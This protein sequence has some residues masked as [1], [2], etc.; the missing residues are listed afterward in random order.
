SEYF[1]VVNRV[2]D[3][4]FDSLFTFT[5]LDSNRIPDNEDP[6]SGAEF[7]FF[8][9]DFTNPFIVKSDPNAGGVFRRFVT[10][11]SGVYVWHVDET[12]VA[13]NLAAGLLPNDFASRKGVDLEEA[14]GIQD[15]DRIDSS[16]SFGSH[17]DSFRAGNNDRFGPDSQPNSAASSGAGT[18]I[19]IRDI[20]SPDSVMALTIEIARTYSETR[21]KWMASGRWQPPSVFDV[22]GVGEEELLVLAD[23]GRVYAFTGAGGEFVDKDGDMTT[24]EP[25]FSAPGAVWVGAPAFGDIDGGGDL[26]IVAASATGTVFAWKGDSTEVFDGDGNPSTR[27]VLYAGAPLAAPPM[28]LDVDDDAMQDIALVEKSGDSLVVAF[29]NGSGVGVLPVDPLI[30]SVWPARI[31]A[32]FCA[33]LAYGALGRNGRDSEGVVIAW[34]DTNRMLYGLSYYPIRVRSGAGWEVESVTFAA[35]GELKATFPPLSSPSVGDLDGDGFE[36]AVLTVADGR[37]AIFA[38]NRIFSQSVSGPGNRT[39]PTTPNRLRMVDLR[40]AGPSAP[41]LGDVDGNG[42]VEI[43]LFDETH[44]YVFENNGRLRTNWPQPIR[45]TS[46]GSFPELVFEQLLTS[47]LV[48]NIDGEGGNEI[49]YPLPDGAIFVFR[50]DGSQVAG[51][52]RAAPSGFGATPTIRDLDGDGELSLVSL[53]VVPLLKTVDSVFDTILVDDMMV[54]S[55]QSLPGSS[56]QNQSFWSMYQHDQLRQGRVT[57]SNPLLTTGDI[58]DPSSFIVYPNPVRGG[59]VH[60]RIILHHS[61]AVGVE[62]FSLEGERAVSKQF[63]WNNTGNAL[64]TPFD[65]VID[66]TDLASGVYLL[67]MS[68]N[69]SSRSESFVKTFAIVRR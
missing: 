4:N 1:L 36:E 55:I 25:Y 39:P 37:L 26:E 28:L 13:Q 12:V 15:M 49:L 54:L 40:S 62:I 32:Q 56:A 18:G 16:F 5:D 22:D 60:A 35:S 19:R 41:A 44:F 24:V 65:E 69:S 61:A 53:G 51:F 67:R 58:T 59:D 64:Q 14:D 43:A 31:Q 11:G 7:D 52:P 57:E 27:G 46:L 29:I 66:V 47:P 34:A 30:Q 21:S 38:P 68:I 23:P 45:P 8:L 9:T 3:T 48:G 50:A 6:L 10:T 42:T 20:S 33:P 63:S 2:H 17:F